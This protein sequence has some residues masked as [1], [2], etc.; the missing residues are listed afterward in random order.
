MF[1]AASVEY[2][3]VNV[4]LPLIF[5]FGLIGNVCV[6]VV[7]TRIKAKLKTGGNN[8]LRILAAND[9]L[10]IAAILVFHGSIVGVELLYLSSS[11]C[12]LFSLLVY[13]IEA[14][15]SF[16]L[17]IVSIDRL[18]L[19]K[20]KS[21][22]LFKQ[23]WFKLSILSAMYT[24]NLSIYSVRSIYVD[25][26]VS[27]VSNAS[28][29][30]SCDIVDPSV[31]HTFAWID[32]VNSTLAPALVMIAC[33]I[34]II[35][36]IYKSRR[37]IVKQKTSAN[38]DLKRLKRDVQFSVTIVMLNVLFLAFNAPACLYNFFGRQG[39][40]LFTLFD[41]FFYCQYITSILVYIFLNRLF[42]D[43]LMLMMQCCFSRQR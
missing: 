6:I 7:F 15:S 27:E 22:T 33:S 1:E 5:V 41:V 29:S 40:F 34:Q 21:V 43:E 32:L 39:D 24:W 19:I 4:C 2:F 35:H 3:L 13:F 14:N 38:A 16:I 17:A 20:Y 42:K 28:R 11:L 9:A 25:L 30:V 8:F 37:R 26:V 10:S 23:K 36:S 12:R 18:L 31:A